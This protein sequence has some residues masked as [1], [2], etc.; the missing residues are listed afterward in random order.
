MSDSE[1]IWPSQESLPS[2]NWPPISQFYAGKNVFITGATGFLG[3]CLIE[4]LLR[5]TP[6]IGKI[7]LLVRSKKGKDIHQR[8][9]DLSK[10]KVRAT[11]QARSSSQFDQK[12]TV[13]LN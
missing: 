9:D 1:E 11:V 8:L 7:Y 10:E 12:S 2:A 3:K 6:D 5:S 13:V 4:K